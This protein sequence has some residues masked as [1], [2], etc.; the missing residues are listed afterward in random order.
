MPLESLAVEIAARAQAGR[1]RFEIRLDPP[2]LGRIDVRLDIDRSGQVTSRLVVEQGGD[3]RRPAPRRAPAR[4]RAAGRRPEDIGQQPAILIARSGLRRPQRPA[5]AP[6]DARTLVA[7]PELPA[8]DRRAACLRA[9]AARRRRHR[10][11][12]LRTPRNPTWPRSS[13]HPSPPAFRR[14]STLR[15]E[16]IVVGASAARSTNN[17]LAGNFQTFLT[18]LT[19]QLKNQNPL[20]PLDTNQFTQQLVQFAQVEQQIKQNSSSRR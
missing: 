11:P 8:T 3:A 10:Y 16:R 2:E 6:T 7:D 4:T 15:H 17:T 1:N 19:T 9:D 18:L 12:R 14:R 13:H 5:A 20:D